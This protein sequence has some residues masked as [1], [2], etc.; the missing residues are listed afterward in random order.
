[1]VLWM[2]EKLFMLIIVNSSQFGRLPD[3]IDI[4]L[5]SKHIDIIFYPIFVQSGI[6]SF[7]TGNF[8]ISKL[9]E[10]VVC[11]NDWNSTQRGKADPTKG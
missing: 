5:L 3:W 11:P 10:G 2:L 6:F 9:K 1:M 8:C 7:N 4:E